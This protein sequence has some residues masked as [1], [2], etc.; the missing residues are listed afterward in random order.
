VYNHDKPLFKTWQATGSRI[1]AIVAVIIVFSY[2]APMA[3]GKSENT[4]KTEYSFI[5]SLAEKSLLLDIVSVDPSRLVAAGERG[6]ILIS[7][8]KGLKWR[9]AKVPTRSTLTA[10]FFINRNYG[11]AVGHD[12]VILATQDGGESWTQQFFAPEKE[13]PLM[14]VCFKDANFGIAIGAYGLYL[15]TRDGG[16]TWVE[17]YFET[18]DDPD[19]GLSHFNAIVMA[20]DNMFFM[21][22]E[23]G[24]L[25]RSLDAGKSWVPLDKPYPGSYFML[26]HTIKDTLIAAGLRGNIYRSADQGI[27]WQKINSNIQSH[28]NQGIQFSDETIILVGHNGV[29][30]QSKDDGMSFK[31]T[32]RS[33]RKA[34]TAAIAV[35]NNEMVVVGESGVLRIAY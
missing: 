26:L 16:K 1:S 20:S 13:Q 32:K 6:H 10:L 19:F 28:I 25:A 12:A 21:A 34:I 29:V 8:D 18:L 3:F 23:A 33:D 9:Q 11:W 31:A 30:L 27:T 17:Q 7:E 5:K 22:G 2:I 14:D 35:G 15:E 24:F 4:A